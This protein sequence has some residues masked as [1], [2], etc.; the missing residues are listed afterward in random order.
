MG[1]I[2]GAWG[3]R[4]QPLALPDDAKSVG[5]NPLILLTNQG[6]LTMGAEETIKALPCPLQFGLLQLKHGSEF[7]MTIHPFL[8]GTSQT[9]QADAGQQSQA[10]L[11]SQADATAE[12]LTTLLGEGCDRSQ[13]GNSCQF[14]CQFRF[15]ALAV[16][17]WS[18]A[19]AERPGVNTWP[20]GR[21]NGRHGVAAPGA[22]MVRELYRPWG[23][24]P[25]EA[26]ERVW[27]S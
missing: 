12:Q 14:R 24:L 18:T 10:E 11:H 9:N 8:I 5:S 22:E 20:G 6:L 13:G 23:A 1:K 25:S 15:S 21:S 26:Q 19:Q 7:P 3:N 4:W 17:C 27:S 16:Q 2:S